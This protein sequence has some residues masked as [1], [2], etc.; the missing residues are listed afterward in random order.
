MARLGIEQVMEDHRIVLRAPHRQT[1]TPQ[2]H[3]I[4]LDVLADLGDRFVLEQRTQQPGILRRRTFVAGHIPGLVRH[5][6][7]RHAHDAVVEEV[8]TSRLRIET[9]LRITAYLGDHRAQFV[10]R[11]DDPVVVRRR[12]RTLHLGFGRQRIRFVDLLIVRHG[13]CRRRRRIGRC[14]EIAL[15]DQRRLLGGSRFGPRHLGQL[16]L[17]VLPRPVALFERRH[18][19]Q[20]AQEHREIQFGEKRTQFVQIGRTHRQLLGAE[21]DRHVQPDRREPLGKQQFVA[22]RG[23]ALALPALDPL[24]VGENVLDR[25]PRLHQ[26]AGT[27]LADA[28]HA[29][30]IVR[31][32]APQRQHVAHERRIVE[33]V[34][35]ADGVAVDDLDAVALLLVELAA[36]AHELPVILVGRHHEDLVPFGGSLLRQGTDHV[37]GLE[38]LDFEHRHAHRIQNPLDIGDRQSDV[39]RR[40]GTVGLVF[41]V[42]FAAETSALWIERHTQQ[43]GI[44]A[45]EDVAQELHETENDRRIHP[46]TV[47][48]RPRQ[49]RIIVFI[50][51]CVGIDQKQF[52]H[53]YPICGAAVRSGTGCAAG[54]RHR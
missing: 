7:E 50:D 24:H 29:G 8:E 27:L 28:R 25:S 22:P 35:C 33:S 13:R 21:F 4:E 5:D 45:F 16:T 34:M 3:Q 1:D 49:K 30:N 37:V 19:L 46:R 31:G 43:V 54:S 18:V 39:L 52:F 38:S 11:A 23:D 26:L 44:F 9:E 12:L 51:Q 10:G 2:H 32:I 41:G 17:R 47:A 15:P 48:H 36:G 42:E 20:I 14:E 40:G 6:G 53:H